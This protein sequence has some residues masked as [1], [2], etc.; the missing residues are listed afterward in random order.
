MT[1]LEHSR[2]ALRERRLQRRR[3]TPV[4]LSNGLTVH[5]A[6]TPVERR[7]EHFIGDY[8]RAGVVEIRPGM[9][10]FDVGANIGMFSLE[11]LRRCDGDARIF[12]FEPARETFGYLERNLRALFPGAP[13]QSICKA[14]AGRPGTATFY[15]R[16]WASGTSSLQSRSPTPTDSRLEA[17]L[18]EPPDEYRNLIPRWFRRLPRPIAKSLLRQGYRL[19][20]NDVVVTQCEVTTVSDV[21]REHDVEQIDY[22]KIDVEGAELDV[23]RGIAH[24]HW[25]RISALGAEIHDVDDRLRT[26][27]ELLAAARFDDVIVEQE[28]PFEGTNVYMVHARRRSMGLSAARTEGTSARR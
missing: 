3:E 17:S 20:G 4:V 8:F 23:L 14:V 15:H 13:V 9:T 19:A 16:P 22:L 24:E 7:F 27:R 28:W 18:R 6:A 11:V 21:I 25:P 26:I 10:V 12:A 1:V 5:G 2:T